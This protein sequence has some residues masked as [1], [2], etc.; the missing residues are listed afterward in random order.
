MGKRQ[1]SR[2][3]LLLWHQEMLLSRWLF[4]VVHGILPCSSVKVM[5]WQ[6]S[7]CQAVPGGSA[8][9][10]PGWS[11]MGSSRQLGKLIYHGVKRVSSG[12][13]VCWQEGWGQCLCDDL[14]RD[15]GMGAAPTFS[16]GSGEY[17]RGVRK[18]AGREKCIQ[19]AR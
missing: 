16:P 2:R 17:I 4:W 11:W 18:C 13:A 19:K 6:G 8:G 12:W 15:R 14:L 9:S 5:P 1:L 7:L 3:A 10:S